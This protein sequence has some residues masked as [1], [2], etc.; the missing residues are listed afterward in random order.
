MNLLKLPLVA[1]VSNEDLAERVKAGDESA[2]NVLFERFYEG[3]KA[4]LSK[5]LSGDLEC[6][7]VAMTA[8]TDAW[9][10]IHRFDPERG[11]FSTWINRCA[12]NRGIDCLRK[13]ERRKLLGERYKPER[14]IFVVEITSPDETTTDVLT[15]LLQ[16]V[17]ETIRNADM[18]EALLMWAVK[19]MSH[20]EISKKLGLPMGTVKAR[21]RRGFKILKERASQRAMSV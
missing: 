15:T 11:K 18:K 14:D 3:V 4:G 20:A 8:F 1:E 12:K 16:F 7:D 6:E 17:D 10:N 13:R 5:M 21:I 9:N 2:F 19:Q